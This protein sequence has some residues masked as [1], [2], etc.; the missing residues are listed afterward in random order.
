L[1]LEEELKALRSKTE[2]YLV[3]LNFAVFEFL[4]Y[5]LTGGEKNLR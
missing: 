2:N 1:Q 4:V 3:G 5:Y